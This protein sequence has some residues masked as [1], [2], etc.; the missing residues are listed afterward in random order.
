MGKRT[1]ERSARFYFLSLLTTKEQEAYCAV[2][3]V[4]LCAK[5]DKRDRRLIK[6]EVATGRR[7]ARVLA[8]ELVRLRTEY[9]ATRLEGE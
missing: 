7:G 8:V 2:S 3:C 4:V 9:D 1:A 5:V 6:H